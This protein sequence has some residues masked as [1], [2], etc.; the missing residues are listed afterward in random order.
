MNTLPVDESDLLMVSQ[1]EP[2]LKKSP[3]NASYGVNPSK[4]DESQPESEIRNVFEL[5]LFMDDQNGGQK[6]TLDAL[7]MIN[8]QHLDKQQASPPR[9]DAFSPL[10]E[11]VLVSYDPHEKAKRLGRPRKHLG[12]M[13][14]ASPDASASE[15]LEKATVSKFRFDDRPVVGPGS[16]GGDTSNRVKKGLVENL[17]KRKQAMLDFSNTEGSTSLGLTKDTIEENS[18]LMKSESHA[19]TS[20]TEL[21]IGVP[22]ADNGGDDV[23]MKEARDVK[24]EF[25]ES[26]KLT[27]EPKR[28]LVVKLS[29]KNAPKKVEKKKD[30]R[31]KI[32]AQNFRNKSTRTTIIREKNRVT[33]TL[34]GPIVPLNFDL[35]DDN[36]I[37]AE[38]NSSA[39]NQPIALGFPVKMCPYLFDIIYVISFLSTFESIINIGFVG[40]EDFEKGLGL[41]IE[42]TAPEED[43][44]SPL[45]E[46]LFRKLLTLVLNRK[47]PVAKG[48]ERPAIQEL[49]GQYISLGLPLEWRDDSAVRKVSNI[50][51]DPALDR[52]DPTKPEIQLEETVEYQAPTETMNP[53]HEKSF[54]E[55]GLIG[56][57][58]PID[59]I[60]LIRCLMLWS[61]SASN[62]MKAHMAAVVNQQEI[63]GERDTL[64]ASRAVLKGFYQ[65]T[66]LKK[67]LEAKLTKRAKP[68]KANP[69]ADNMNY[70]DPAS[71]PLAHPMAL[72]LNEFVVGDC[73]F[74]MGR[75]Y[76]VRM[77]NPS[78]GGLSSIE[79]MRSVAN[80]YT[81]VRKSVPSGFKLYVEDVHAVLTSSLAAYGPEFDVRGKEVRAKYQRYDDT[82]NWYQV[83]S[84]AEEMHAFVSHLEWKLGIV[85][86][87]INSVSQNTAAYRPILYMYQYLKHIAPLLEDFEQTTGFIDTRSARKK[88]VDYKQKWEEEEE[89]RDAEGDEEEEDYSEEEDDYQE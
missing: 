85:E 73:G 89:Y 13:Q 62:V 3:A 27:E 11:M 60:I 51:C 39:A 7:N 84:N 71:D 67:E 78:G 14:P 79:K 47:K 86:N 2:T 5:Q 20:A 63:P 32:R 54:E 87:N 76:L 48:G 22:R 72:R 65:T 69:I 10:S 88:K 36:L 1:I 46:N 33:R 21:Q 24:E 53:F 41:R 56:I 44:V 9:K 77:A 29:L 83:A 50:P 31:S 64:Y 30:S 80:G 15:N 34:P 82:K 17:K 68:T 57:K 38:A 58:N 40:P 81:S 43:Y 55:Q 66:E 26:G 16:R 70:I 8:L 18:D 12:G 59:R 42:T 61:L 37:A 19:D 75:F 49:Q 28:S 4:Q 45:M 25:A 52:V 6:T 35:Y 74:H 23:E